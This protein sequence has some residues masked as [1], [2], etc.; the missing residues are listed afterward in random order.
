MLAVSRGW[1]CPDWPAPKQVTAFTT[2]RVGGVSEGPWS[3]FNLGN[4]CGD[5][6]SRVKQNRSLLRAALP[7]PVQWLQQVHGT[8]VVQPTGK[9]K[10][11]P[12]GDAMVTFE[13]GRVCAVLTADCLPVMFCNRSGNRV[14]AAHAGWR[15]LADGVLEATVSAM[16]EDPAELMAWL[17]PA[18]GPQA[19][20]V[21]SDVAQA[22]AEEFPLGFA[23]RGDR[24]LMDIYALARLKLEAAG[25]GSVYGGGFCTLT[26]ADRF[27]SYRRDAVTGRMASVVWFE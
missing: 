18:I 6:P 22:F 13:A 2:T 24:F 4:R 12:E 3:S 23:V 20:E 25:V 1:I 15:G 11:E 8:T 17:G 9:I 14:G 7:A 10:Q 5:D 16:D 21:G 27:F 19:Y 26:D